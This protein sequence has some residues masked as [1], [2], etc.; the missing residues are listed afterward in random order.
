M[1]RAR[2]VVAEVRLERTWLRPDG[3]AEEDEYLLLLR[4]AAE[5]EVHWRYRVSQRAGRGA[6]HD[7]GAIVDLDARLLED[8]RR[9]GR[10]TA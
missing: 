9:D 3:Q 4:Q 8:A 10:S 6:P 1:A 5:S 2:F 7:V